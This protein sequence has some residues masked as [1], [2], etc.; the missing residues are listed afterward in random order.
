[1]ID[2]ASLWVLTHVWQLRD[3]Q[4]GQAA[5]EYGVLLALILIVAI[6]AITVLGGNISDAF[7]AV[8]KKLP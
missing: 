1:M 2:R 6:G 5:A 8:A 3:R 7:D 4:D